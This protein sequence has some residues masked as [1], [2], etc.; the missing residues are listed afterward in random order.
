MNDEK[1]SMK[2]EISTKVKKCAESSTIVSL[3]RIATTDRKSIKLMW[4]FFTLVC[5]GFCLF[6]IEENVKNYL[7]FNVVTRVR[8]INEFPSDFPTISI[9][10]LNQFTTNYSVQ[11]LKNFARENNY[12]DIFNLTNLDLLNITE[13]DS[14]LSVFSDLALFNVSSLNLT[15]DEKMRFSFAM[16]EM[17]ISCYYD[18][19][20][21]AFSQFEYYFDSIM[22]NCYKFNSGRDL[23][24]FNI[25]PYK[26]LR[27]GRMGGLSIELFVGV[28]FELEPITKRYGIAVFVSRNNT[29][30]TS[31]PSVNV[32]PGSEANLVVSRRVSKKLPKPYSNCSALDTYDSYLFKLFAEKGLKYRQYDCVIQCYQHAIIEKCNCHDVIYTSF[33][34]STPCPTE[35]WS[36]LYNYRFFFSTEEFIE[37]NCFD[38][39]PLEC[40]TEDYQVSY[41]M[42]QYPT[43][44]Y[45]NILSNYVHISKQYYFKNRLKDNIVS[46]NVYL[47]SL[48]YMSIEEYASLDIITLL[49]NL[50]GVAGLFLGLSVL[51]FVEAI[52]VI[53]EL[54][55]ALYE[56]K[57]KSNS[58]NKHKITF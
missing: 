30:F 20:P 17:L 16:D 35:S 19:V 14:L 40:E 13:Y 51:T 49:S 53:M 47:E 33:F 22:G 28:P 6:L 42:N 37:A 26:A 39:C 24:G 1:F 44:F 45:E 48:S 18:N 3:S 9:C 36:C 21:C 12:P 10:N 23:Y 5:T 43:D 7:E 11:F 2:S 54:V 34:N 57:N 32:Y 15:N 25:N 41:S 4:T 38:V 55:Q 50:G 46:F 58:S 52:Q 29:L 31:L 56:S 8:I 27:P